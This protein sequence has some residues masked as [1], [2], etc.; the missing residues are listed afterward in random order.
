MT[1]PALGVVAAIAAVLFAAAAGA[2]EFVLPDAASLAAMS[3]TD[4]EALAR[5][6]TIEA[7]DWPVTEVHERIPAPDPMIE[8]HVQRRGTM[9]GTGDLYRAAARVQAIQ[10]E[11]ER[12]VRIEELD[13]VRGPDMHVALVSTRDPDDFDD[14]GEI[15]D[16]GPL[17]AHRGNLTYA[18]P[19]GT[20]LFRAVAI[21]SLRLEVLFAAAPLR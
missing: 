3:R 5:A 12:Y 14:L 7:Q 21:V 2:Q 11:A 6:L 9:R 19:E 20:P 18:L 16:L 8:P 4:K 1:R 17:R 13:I 10:V 15:S